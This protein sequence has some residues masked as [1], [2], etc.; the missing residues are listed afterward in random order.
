[1]KETVTISN[2]NVAS[3]HEALKS[4]PYVQAICIQEN[5]TSERYELTFKYAADL[6]YIGQTYGLQLTFDKYILNRKP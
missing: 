4:Y 1:M 2:D 5:E 6:F 3:F